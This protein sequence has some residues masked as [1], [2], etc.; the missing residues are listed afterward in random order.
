MDKILNLIMGILKSLSE[1]LQLPSIMMGIGFAIAGLSFAMLARRITRI[2]RRKNE[3]ADDDKI[4][5]GIKA[6][7]LI[8]L[9]VALLILVLQPNY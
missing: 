1:R 9:F 3:I 6:V 2:I 8:L 5:I 7:G 4:M